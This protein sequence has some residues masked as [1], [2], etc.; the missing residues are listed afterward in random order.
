MQGTVIRL[1][2][3][4]TFDLMRIMF[5]VNALHATNIDMGILTNMLSIYRDVSEKRDMKNL[6]TGETNLK[7][8]PYPK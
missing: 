5:M 1:A 6:L 8:T 7:I 4:R 2:L 3:I